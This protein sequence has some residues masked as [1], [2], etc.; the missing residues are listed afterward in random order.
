[1]PKFNPFIELSEDV[2]IP[3]LHVFGAVIITND[4]INGLCHELRT[5]LTSLCNA[6]Y[7]IDGKD[8]D[9]KSQ[10][11]LKI[12][13]KSA[14]EV[15]HKFNRFIDGNRW[16]N[17]EGKILFNPIPVNL[18]E[19]LESL[20]SQKVQIKIHPELMA[21]EFTFDPQYLG[22]A[23]EEIINNGYFFNRSKKKTVTIDA[24]QEDE[25][26]C[27]DFTDNGK[28]IAPNEWEKIFHL[29][30]VCGQSRNSATSGFGAGL[31]IARGII[32]SMG[33]M[34]RVQEST[35]GNGSTFR[36]T[37]PIEKKTDV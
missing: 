25:H 2:L 35:I 13:E 8:L 32:K 10:K 20:T 34:V 21:E 16:Q 30:Y 1:M 19:F 31:T 3:P 14:Q 15:G 36:V 6:S 22:K 27:L 33:G 18:K 29:V 9:K 7:L 4:L 17:E 11:Y 26:L 37:L 28:G 23:F 5:P 12:L 24:F